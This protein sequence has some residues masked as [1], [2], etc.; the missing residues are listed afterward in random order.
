MPSA[1]RAVVMC[2]FG[3]A[4]RGAE[5]YGGKGTQRVVWGAIATRLSEETGLRI[6]P[7]QCKN[8]V[9]PRT[10]TVIGCLSL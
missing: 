5:S 4:A 9:R 1:E 2:R 7:E 10:L 3:G 8:K 6:E